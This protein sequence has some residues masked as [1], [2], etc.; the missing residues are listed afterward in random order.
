MWVAWDWSVLLCLVSGSPQPRTLFFFFSIFQ[1]KIHKLWH[2][3]CV[4]FSII[5]FLRLQTY[6]IIILEK[7]YPY[8]EEIKYCWR[9][10]Q[11]PRRFDLTVLKENITSRKGLKVA[12]RTR[13]YAGTRDFQQ[14][15]WSIKLWLPKRETFTILESL[16]Q[17]K[18]IVWLENTY[19]SDGIFWRKMN[20]F[21][22]YLHCNF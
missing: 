18:K 13:W 11:F 9:S 12:K 2:F 8:I 1:S 19:D 17:L 7:P 21:F 6:Q 4:L 5:S 16:S 10:G 14:T 15:W 3:V 20:V 22:I